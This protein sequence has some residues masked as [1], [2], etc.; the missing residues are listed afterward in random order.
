MTEEKKEYKYMIQVGSS[1]K[2]TTNQDKW[3]NKEIECRATVRFDEETPPKTL[4]EIKQ[5][6]EH[7]LT[8]WEDE[9]KDT[10]DLNK[11]KDYVEPQSRRMI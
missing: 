8:D 10:Y 11:K 7:F 6:I 2:I 4:D 9:I 5:D 1:R 3:E